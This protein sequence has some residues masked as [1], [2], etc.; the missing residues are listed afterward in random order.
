MS[1]VRDLPEAP[2]LT[3]DDLLYAVEESAGPNGGRKVKVS[4]IRTAVELNDA[5]VK[6]KYEANADT[7]AFTDAEKTK[8]ATIESGAQF[9]DA[10]EV[11]Y[12][13]TVSGLS[14]TEVQTAIDQV[15]TKAQADFRPSIVSGRI[16]NYTGGTV[17]FDGVFTQLVSN[18]ILLN[19]NI[20]NGEVYVDLDGIVKQTG[21]GVLAP[22]YTIV[23]A[24]FSTDLNNITSLTDER[25][26]NAQNIVRGILSDVRDVRAGAAASE[27]TSG[28]VSDAMHKHNILTSSASGLTADSINAEGT[29]TSLA[30]ADHSHDLSTDA[31]ST[32]TPDQTNAEGSSANLARAD[33]IHNIPAAAP[34]TTLSPATTNDKGVAAS[35][36]LSDHAH[37]VATGL[38]ADIS[39]IQP[40][41]VA[42]AGTANTFARGDH[43]HAIVAAAPSDTGTANA[44]G[45]STSFARADHTHNT[46]IANS[47]AT[48][49]ADDTTTSATDVVIVGM[50]LTPAAGTYVAIFSSS[51]LNSGNG[52]TR[53]FFSI[54]SGGSQVTHSERELGIA[55]SANVA[56]HTAATVTVNGSQAIDVRWRAVAGTNT[57]HERS[58]T[59]IRLG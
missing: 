31:P 45:S 26:K 28:R 10:S 5:E 9:Q 23:F 48:A 12:S 30:R 14:A 35:V 3:Q 51:G 7:N 52:A 40:D 2:S 22:P 46:V 55:A 21:S 11:P 20:T 49:T 44:E 1:K 6:T 58:L 15:N 18:D 57:V 16:L 32:Q 42:A 50:T 27:G 47:S 8:L 38:T 29:S 25:V 24:K 59:L 54:Y 13:N 36:A 37:A 17:R 43:K 19:Q 4:T 33:H 39:T 56:I 41:D 53:M 34:I